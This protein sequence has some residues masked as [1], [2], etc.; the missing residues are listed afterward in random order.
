MVDKRVSEERI[1]L[2]LAV[3]FPDELDLI[4]DNLELL[5]NRALVIEGDYKPPVNDHGDGQPAVKLGLSSLRL[6]TETPDHTKQGLA[7]MMY[8]K[9]NFQKENWE[10][11]GPRLQESPDCE[12]LLGRG[13]SKESS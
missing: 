5:P 13:V 1:K 6:N 10:D 8:T 7:T 9:I 12:D 3:L 2:N 4:L 11:K